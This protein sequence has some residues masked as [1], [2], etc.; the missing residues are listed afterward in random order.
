M[1]SMIYLYKL[2]AKDLRWSADALSDAAGSAVRSGEP[3]LAVRLRAL[4]QQFGSAV[5]EAMRRENA[6]LRQAVELTL[7]ALDR[8]AHGESFNAVIDETG[9]TAR[10]HA[11]L[12]KE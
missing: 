8:L 12:G 2:G 7:V 10:L 9:L 3:Q 6:A 1:S 4:S 11:A 5:P